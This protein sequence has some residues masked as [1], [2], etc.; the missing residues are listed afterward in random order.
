MDRRAQSGLSSH[1]MT[2]PLRTPQTLGFSMPAEWEEHEATWLAWPHNPTDWPDKLDIVRWVYGEI[3]RKIAP[4]EIVRMVV[5]SRKEEKLARACLQRAG[6]GTGRVEFVV[7]PTNRGWTRDSGPVFVRRRSPKRQRPP[8][9][10]FTS[11]HGRSIR[12]GGRTAACPPPRPNISANDCSTPGATERS[13]C[14]KAAA[15]T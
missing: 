6:A 10:T 3:V 2:N 15:S 7:H 1:L 14:S 13:S 8:S 9:S 11:T 5:G 4:G 12:I